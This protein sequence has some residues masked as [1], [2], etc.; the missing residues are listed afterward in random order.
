MSVGLQETDEAGYRGRIAKMSEE[1]L[2]R[3][4]RDAW[5]LI[6]NGSAACSPEFKVQYDLA[7]EEWRRRHPKPPEDSC[8]YPRFASL[9]FIVVGIADT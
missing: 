6:K 5:Y 3:Y 7:V 9:D 8:Q 2:K 1:Q 4:G